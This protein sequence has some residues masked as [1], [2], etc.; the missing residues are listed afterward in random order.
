M[1]TVRVFQ[2][3][4]QALVSAG[5]GDFT[6]PSCGGGEPASTKPTCIPQ[7]GRVARLLLLGAG[8]ARNTFVQILEQVRERDRFALVGYVVMPD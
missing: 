4:G 2:R 7:T 6:S 8:K 1:T 5:S 3:T